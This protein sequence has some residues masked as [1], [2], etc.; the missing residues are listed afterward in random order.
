M[1]YQ[2]LRLGPNKNPLANPQA[3]RGE[4]GKT[5]TWKNNKTDG[6]QFPAALEFMYTAAEVLTKEQRVLRISG[7]GQAASGT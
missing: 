3:K 1:D 4:Y 2:R 5:S 7:F 6:P